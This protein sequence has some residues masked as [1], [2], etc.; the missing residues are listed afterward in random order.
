MSYDD[1]MP[2]GC[3]AFLLVALVAF[4]LIYGVAR[5]N[6]GEDISRVTICATERSATSD[7]GEYRIY[8]DHGTYVMEDVFF[9]GGHRLNT[10]DDYGRLRVGTTY[11]IHTVGWRNGFL[12][13]FKNIT[14]FKK[15]QT[16]VPNA[17]DG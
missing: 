1:E 2:L 15:S 16:Q 4:F 8:T 14:E 6:S 13:M 12:S 11:D 3:A 7:G 9:I 5:A 10:A 17:C